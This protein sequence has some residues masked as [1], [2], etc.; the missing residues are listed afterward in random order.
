MIKNESAHL[1]QMI[2]VFVALPVELFSRIVSRSSG[3][4]LGL[5]REVLEVVKKADG[6]VLEET[7]YSGLLRYYSLETVFTP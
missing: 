7:H 5:Q 1:I 6:V 2:R 3:P 4:Q